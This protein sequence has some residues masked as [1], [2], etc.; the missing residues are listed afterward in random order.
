AMSKKLFQNA[1]GIRGDGPS[2]ENHNPETGERLNARKV[3][4]SARCSYLLYQ[5]FFTKGEA[6]L[7]AA[8]VTM[9]G[10]QLEESGSV[11]N[12]RSARTLTMHVTA[13]SRYEEQELAEKVVKHME[14]FKLL[15][16]HQKE[17]EWLSEGAYN[18]LKSN[19]N[20]LIKKWQ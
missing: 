3:S 17:N 20:D 19:T 5:D 18:M 1:E 16:N 2:G 7:S 14:G 11:V 9:L 15:L 13:V 8:G 12:A 10:T 4:W 6:A